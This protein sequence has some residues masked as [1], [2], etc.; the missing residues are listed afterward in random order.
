[1][2]YKRRW[3]E[4]KESKCPFSI[5]TFRFITFCQR[6]LLVTT[7]ICHL[8]IWLTSCKGFRVYSLMILAITLLVK[9]M[10]AQYLS[11][12]VWKLRLE[13][14]AWIDS[15]HISTRG[16]ERISLNLVF[17][18]KPITASHWSQDE[19]WAPFHDHSMISLLLTHLFS[20]QATPLLAQH[21]PRMRSF[22]QR[23]KA[24]QLF[25]VSGRA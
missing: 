25:P 4:D 17:H 2:R 23:K 12:T 21:A 16:R 6:R 9:S 14:F 8:F 7:A 3:D 15:N 18:L 19:I 1:M 24:P 5:S 11:C 22:L 10:G 13:A 20:F